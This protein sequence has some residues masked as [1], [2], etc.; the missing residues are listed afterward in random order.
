MNSAPI[1]ATPTLLPICRA[2]STDEVAARQA[3]LHGPAD[4]PRGKRGM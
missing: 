4:D 3:S 1:R 2:K